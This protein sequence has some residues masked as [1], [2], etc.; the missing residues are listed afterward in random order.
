MLALRYGWAWLAMGCLILI[1][2]L[3][4]AL[5]PGS[6]VMP[7]S[8]SDKLLHAGAFAAFMVWFSGIFEPRYAPRIALALFGYGA[9]IEG[10]QSFTGF[11]TAELG[12]LVA[13]GVGILIGWA[14]GAAGLRHWCS[15][16]ERWLVRPQP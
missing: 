5:L 7:L 12:D 14:V 6:T 15:F 10:L 1:T 9:M 4:V 11:R 8:I 2:G 13:D 3:V 16:L